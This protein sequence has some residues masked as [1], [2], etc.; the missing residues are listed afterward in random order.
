[1]VHLVHSWTC[2]SPKKVYGGG[3]QK[4]ANFQVCVGLYIRFAVHTEWPN[5]IPIEFFKPIC[6]INFIF[7]HNALFDGGHLVISVF[8]AVIGTV[9]NSP[10]QR[11]NPSND[12]SIVR[13]D[14]CLELNVN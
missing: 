4:T 1:M 3:V 10:A 9:F 13:L 14:S 2:G 7:S 6:W 11:F 12:T 5:I 8:Y